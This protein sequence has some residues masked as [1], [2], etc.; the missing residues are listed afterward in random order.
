MTPIRSI[1][2]TT[3]ISDLIPLHSGQPGLRGTLAVEIR[4]PQAADAPPSP[5][6]EGRGEG[7]TASVGAVLDFVSS[8]STL[9][10]YGELIT[11]F[12]TQAE[13]TVYQRLPNSSAILDGYPI[14]WTDV[15]EPC[16][17]A[18]SA[19]KPIAVFAALSI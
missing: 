19:N 15:L 10:R 3:P 13:P 9:D 4:T 7:G 12:R 16:G 18:A 14:I 8:D 11:S 17:T 6:G 1:P 2:P 5:G